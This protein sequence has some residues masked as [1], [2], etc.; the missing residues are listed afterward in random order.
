[1]SSF[2]SSKALQE[3]N[4]RQLSVGY[5]GQAVV[6]EVSFDLTAGQIGCLLGPSGCGKSTLLRAI[7]GFESVLSGAILLNGEQ[8]SS[9]DYLLPPEQRQ[10]G[11]VFQD[12]AL[13]P[14]LTIAEN[15][16]FG[17]KDKDKSAQLARVNELLELIGL[18]GFGA[19][20]PHSLSGGQQQRVALARAMAPKPKLLLMD[21]PFSG[22][23]AKLREELVPDIR[24]ILKHEGMSAIL[25]THDQ[26]EA[27]AMADMIAVMAS[28]EIHQFGTPYQ[29][30]H[31]PESRFT[32][33]FVGQGDFLNAV[34]CDHHCLESDLGRI[35]GVLNDELAIGTEVDLLVRPDDVI[36]DDNSEFK[37]LVMSK[38]F[39][40]SH[41]LYR[42]KLASGLVVYCFASSHHN[43]TIGQEIGINIEL[44]HLVVFT[45]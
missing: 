12:I 3:L 36:H 32:A 35:R 14:H 31:R 29:I 27:F 43:H 30:Y 41:F 4:I 2:T 18:P 40:G 17:L 23:D 1:M 22:L 25:V 16:A 20:Y 33:K 45:K 10:I 24:N 19:R 15:I 37:G 6:H 34:V 44:D 42:V 21:E 9:V 13:F 28:G 38:W 5:H 26:M 8:I 39:R 7:A 11:M